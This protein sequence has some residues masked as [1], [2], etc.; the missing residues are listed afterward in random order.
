MSN[1]VHRYFQTRVANVHKIYQ[2]LPLQDPP[3]F[4]QIRMFGLK[5]VYHLA[6]LFQ[7]KF[8]SDLGGGELCVLDQVEFCYADVC[9]SCAPTF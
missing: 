7:T 2:H 9:E 6:T 1:Y 8:I 4:A 5:M 3:K